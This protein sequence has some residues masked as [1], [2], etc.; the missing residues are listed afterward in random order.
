MMNFRENMAV[1]NTLSIEYYSNRISFSEYRSERTRL[2]QLLDEELNGVK[3]E[4][5]K[6]EEDESLLDKTLFFLKLNKYKEI[7]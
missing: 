5:L 3:I 2:L 4:Y 6:Q 7:N 1:L